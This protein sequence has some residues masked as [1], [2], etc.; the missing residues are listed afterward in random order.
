M[1]IKNLNYKST[2]DIKVLVLLFYI[3]P[4]VAEKRSQACNK[5][6]WAAVFFGRD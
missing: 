6:A 2:E 3:N 4:T 5:E 1:K